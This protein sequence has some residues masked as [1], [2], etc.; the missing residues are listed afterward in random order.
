[1]TTKEIL[2]DSVK[3][4]EELNKSSTSGTATNNPE[5]RIVRL[6]LSDQVILDTDES[7][8]ELLR[9]C[10]RFGDTDVLV[11]IPAYGQF[12]RY[13]I[14]CAELFQIMSLGADNL[15]LPEDMKELAESDNFQQ[16]ALLSS[17]ALR[18]KVIRDL[19]ED[20]FF[21][22]LRVEI[23]GKDFSPEIE[24]KLI[25][26]LEYRKKIIFQNRI[27]KLIFWK[28]NIE[29]PAE[30]EYRDAVTE[31]KKEW[32]RENIG[33]DDL[34]KLFTAILCCNDMIKKKS[35]WILKMNYQTLISQ[36]STP[37]LKTSGVSQS[38]KSKTHPSSKFVSF[39]L[40]KQSTT[41][42]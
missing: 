26:L 16:W 17:I 35:I 11:R 10:V 2:A 1:M 19:V 28:K 7:G 41:T 38:Q 36:A 30:P 6:N 20:I 40:D 14:K 13:S 42:N 8:N 32:A 34:F 9:L 4:Y 29:V 18:A 24:I 12:E 5:K 33:V 39:S 27:A 31:V 23:T 37:I 22:Y 21:R 15:Q 25:A 3:R